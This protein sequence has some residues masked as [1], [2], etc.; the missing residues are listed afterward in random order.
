[1]A[2]ELHEQAGVI[3]G[4]YGIDELKKFQNVLEGYQLHVVSADHFNGI[5]YAG[6]EEENKIYLYYH[7]QHYDDITSMDAFFTK[8]YYCIQCQK[9]YDKK[10]KHACNNACHACKK[11]HDQSE[12][13]WVR[14]DDCYRFF[15][16]QECFKLHKKTTE[17]GNSTCRIYSRCADCGKTI[18]KILSSK[19][20]QCGSTYCELCKDFFEEEHNCYMLPENN[21]L[22]S[23]EDEDNVDTYIFFDL[24]VDRMML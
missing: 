23:D 12:D 6:P 2:E 21:D 4:S 24:E 16:G 15:R 7:N 1:M 5:I 8:R 18:N 10:E 9:G 11:I 3:Q 13:P 19:P 17:K 14:C 20:H 22:T